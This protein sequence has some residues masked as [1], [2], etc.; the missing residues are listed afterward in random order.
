VPNSFSAVATSPQTSRANW[1]NPTNYQCRCGHIPPIWDDAKESQSEECKSFG[2]HIFTWC[3]RP[4]STPEK[5]NPAAATA[6]VSGKRGIEIA[7]SHQG[8]QGIAG[9][10]NL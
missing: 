10:T 2:Y 8:G 6:T 3:V 7:E 9:R 5:K 1:Y 4:A